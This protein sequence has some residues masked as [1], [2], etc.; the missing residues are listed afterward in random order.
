MVG[1][2][3]EKMIIPRK[4]VENFKGQI[5]EVIKLEAPDGNIYNVHT[6]KDPNKIHLGSGWAS[7]ANLYELK[8]ATCWC[9]GTSGIPTSKF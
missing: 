3:H 6:I 8:E 9:S 1:D 2:F 7:F 5:A 4:F